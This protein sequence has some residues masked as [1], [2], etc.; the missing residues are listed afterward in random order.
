MYVCINMISRHALVTRV[1]LALQCNI[2][3]VL[4]HIYD[5]YLCIY[6][7]LIVFLFIT[8]D[9]CNTGCV[10]DGLINSNV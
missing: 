4:T 5:I 1:L 6:L 9:Y 8:C 10:I 2:F 7:C 3:P